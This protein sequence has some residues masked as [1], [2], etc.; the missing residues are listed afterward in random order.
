MMLLSADE[1][2]LRVSL[3]TTPVGLDADAGGVLAGDIVGTQTGGQ[4]NGYMGVKLGEAFKFGERAQRFDQVS[5]QELHLWG[6]QVETMVAST[7]E[8]MEGESFSRFNAALWTVNPA[9]TDARSKPRE[10]RVLPGPSGRYSGPLFTM[11]WASVDE[12]VR[13]H[14]VYRS[15]RDGS[16]E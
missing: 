3:E 8:P 16:L 5:G 11:P 6:G 12:Q 4:R 14:V 15:Q 13:F 10:A 7:S 2:P 9:W 1:S